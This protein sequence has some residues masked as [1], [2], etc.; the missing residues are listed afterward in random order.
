M[1]DIANNP[2]P[3]LRCVQVLE[4][5]VF[6]LILAF[7]DRRTVQETQLLDVTLAAEQRAP[8]LKG[9]RGLQWLQRMKEWAIFAFIA[10]PG[11][12]LLV[13][14]LPATASPSDSD[15]SRDVPISAAPPEGLHIE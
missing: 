13:L 10:C 8:G 2:P 1:A 15:I 6:P 4:S 11:V 12:P 5:S 14:P 3:H 7:K 9:W